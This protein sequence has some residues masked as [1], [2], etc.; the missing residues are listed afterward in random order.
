MI[1]KKVGIPER[2]YTLH[3]AEDCNGV[4]TN[5][6]IKYIMGVPVGSMDDSVKQYK[7]SKN[8]CKK[9]LKSLKKQNKMIYSIDKKSGSHHYSVKIR[10]KASKKCSNSSSDYSDSN[11][12][13]ASDSS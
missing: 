12:L 4:Q 13:L 3:S 2:K 10:A 8:K 7:K 6:S 11:S 9:D 1:C 5:R